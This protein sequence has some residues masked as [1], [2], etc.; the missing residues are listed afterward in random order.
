MSWSLYAEALAS[1]GRPDLAEAAVA[2]GLQHTRSPRL[3]LRQAMLLLDRGDRA[4]ALPLLRRS[5]EEGEPRAMANLA[6]LELEAGRLN[7]A[8]AWA[9]KGAERAPG[10]AH[11][12]RTRGRAALATDHLDEALAEFTAALRLE[13]SPANRLN[14][15]LALLALRRPAEAI[16]HLEAIAADPALGPRARQLL[17]T[18]RRGPAPTAAPTAPAAPRVPSHVP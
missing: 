9:R 6:I 10:L 7:D 16:R 14:L 4:G 13:Q 12:R 2:E 17:E 1:V 3:V 18:A 15:A 8:L 5:A 11:A